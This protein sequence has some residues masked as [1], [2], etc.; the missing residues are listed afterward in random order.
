MHTNCTILNMILAIASRW[1][2]QFGSLKSIEGSF[3]NFLQ[4]NTKVVDSDKNC[5]VLT[6]WQC[7]R[8]PLT[9][10]SC[11]STTFC[12]ALLA[13]LILYE[14]WF[15]LNC[16]W[17][18]WIA[19]HASYSTTSYLIRIRETVTRQAVPPCTIPPQIY[20]SNSTN[21]I[22]HTLPL[23][24]QHHISACFSVNANLMFTSPSS[25]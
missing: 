16:I 21:C 19:M 10:H 25:A 12:Q 14:H 23:K 1:F 9:W 8:W 6:L 4:H 7:L 20:I 11:H 15:K 24:N 18:L 22:T 13:R 3:V 2:L 17:L 5:P